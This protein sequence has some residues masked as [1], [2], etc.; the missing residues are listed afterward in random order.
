MQVAA[1]SGARLEAIVNMRVDHAEGPLSSLPRRRRR[2]ENRPCTANS[3]KLWLAL[4]QMDI[5]PKVARL[6]PWPS[7]TIGQGAGRGSQ[8]RAGR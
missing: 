3:G 8:G 5:G 4:K 2:T 1:L 6:P 7:H